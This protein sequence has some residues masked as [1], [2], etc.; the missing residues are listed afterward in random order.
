MGMFSVVEVVCTVLNALAVI[1][2]LTVHKWY[3]L[4]KEKIKNYEILEWTVGICSSAITFLLTIVIKHIRT[5][6]KDECIKLFNSL[7]NGEYEIELFDNI[8][9]MIP[10]CDEK[11][12]VKKINQKAHKSTEKNRSPVFS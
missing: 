10:S 4:F 6:T 3:R 2:D 1:V 7:E 9:V 12:R 11:S 8:E 5:L